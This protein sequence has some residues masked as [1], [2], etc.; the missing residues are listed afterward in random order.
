MGVKPKAGHVAL[1]KLIAKLDLRVCI[2][3]INAFEEYIREAHNP[4]FSSISTRT[5]TGDI[6]KY[7]V[8]VVVRLS[9]A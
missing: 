9:I 2:G 7:L 8:S 6:I 4:R 3:E 5:T 1:C